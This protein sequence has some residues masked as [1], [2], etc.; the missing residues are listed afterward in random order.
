MFDLGEPSEASGH[1]LATMLELGIDISQGIVS[2][3]SSSIAT[4]TG[5]LNEQGKEAFKQKS[6]GSDYADKKNEISEKP[7]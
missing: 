2:Q 5:R 6:M 4:N 1:H 7:V 3:K